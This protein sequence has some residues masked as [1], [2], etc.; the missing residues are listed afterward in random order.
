M[1]V[2]LGL[3]VLLVALNTLL[4]AHVVVFPDSWA[5]RALR[6]QILAGAPGWPDLA[7]A[8]IGFTVIPIAWLLVTR[9]VPWAGTVQYL[10][11]RW[12]RT[13]ILRGLALLAVTVAVG[14]VLMF[15][16]E[17]LPSDLE[18][19]YEDQWS[20]APWILLV[21]VS[22]AA[23]VGEEIFFRGILQRWIG[24]WAQGIV[25]ALAHIAFVP[26]EGVAF[27][28]AI[29]LGLGWLRKIGWSLTSLM[30]AHAFYDVIAMVFTKLDAQGDIA[31]AWGW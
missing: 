6:E 27:F 29:G 31:L 30:I 24:W 2:L 15:V 10:D 20:R 22:L 28:F 25:F 12:D 1:H 4:V 16:S 11:L 26:I 8:I 13:V 18:D 19:E 17:P 5:G 21:L 7:F 23:G 9:R 14:A 3:D